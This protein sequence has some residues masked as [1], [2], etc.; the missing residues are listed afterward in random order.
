MN[1]I[2]MAR[3]MLLEANIDPEA[4]DSIDGSVP[5]AAVYDA[6]DEAAD[7][8]A[9]GDETETSTEWP[10]VESVVEPS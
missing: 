10:T 8:V 6:L 3:E 2:R 5:A 4:V 9:Y 7:I 1:T